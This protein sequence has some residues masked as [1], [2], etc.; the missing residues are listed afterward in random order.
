MSRDD[1]LRTMLLDLHA[2][3]AKNSQLSGRRKSGLRLIKDVEAMAAESVIEHGEEPLA[4]GSLVGFHAPIRCQ[5]ARA[6]P[7]PRRRLLD[8]GCNVVEA[9][10]AQ[11]EAVLLVAHTAD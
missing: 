8:T 10:G 7:R 4:M 5:D 2:Q 11:K 6:F 9:F 1:E 3:E